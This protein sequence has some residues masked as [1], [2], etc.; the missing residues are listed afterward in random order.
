MNVV[1]RFWDKVYAH[2]VSAA[3]HFGMFDQRLNI[4][5]HL[6]DRKANGADMKQR[7]RGRNGNSGRAH[8]Q[9]GHEFNAEN[10]YV[11]PNGVKRLC[12]ACR[13]GSKCEAWR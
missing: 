1:E 8:C 3:I 10:T 2:R 5:H 4:L 6:G 11:Y 9:R 12:R 13:A 7:G